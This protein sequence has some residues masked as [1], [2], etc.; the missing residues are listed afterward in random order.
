MAETQQQRPGNAGLAEMIVFHCQRLSIRAAT[1]VMV[2]TL[3]TF[4]AVM[5]M[6]IRERRTQITFGAR[7]DGVAATGLD[8][9]LRMLK[10]N[11]TQ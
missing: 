8:F 6:A 3:R 5:L 9:H 2:V 11:R 7:F 4:L 1:I 10:A